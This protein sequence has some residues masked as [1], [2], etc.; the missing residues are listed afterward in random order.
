MAPV[1]NDSRGN[2]DI[3]SSTSADLPASSPTVILGGDHLLSCGSGGGQKERHAGK[4]NVTTRKLGRTDE[5]TG[6]E[7]EILEEEGRGVALRDSR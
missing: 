5:R 7:H 3:T 4:G 2:E 1:L 6:D